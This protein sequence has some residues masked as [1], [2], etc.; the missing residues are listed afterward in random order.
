MEQ[1]EKAIGTSAQ[2]SEQVARQ[3]DEGVLQ[4]P[5]RI[6]REYADEFRELARTSESDH[7]RAL[8][9]KTVH[10]WLD[11]ATRF[12]MDDYITEHGSLQKP[13]A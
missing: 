5:P 6:Y 1:D 2:L 4:I 12:E 10:M 7:Q 13:A 11:A 8:Y 9:L 3:A